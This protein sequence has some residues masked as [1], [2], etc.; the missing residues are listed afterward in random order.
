MVEALQSGDLGRCL[1]LN[2]ENAHLYKEHLTQSIKASQLISDISAI[3]R[4]AF[5]EAYIQGRKRAARLLSDELSV[6]DLL[7]AKSKHEAE[8]HE[9][10][11]YVLEAMNESLSERSIN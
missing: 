9:A 11:C 5:Q 2:A 10:E 1:E 3:D 8:C 4:D 7:G 6:D